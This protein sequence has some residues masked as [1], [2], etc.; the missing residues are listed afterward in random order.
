M[1][2]PEVGHATLYLDTFVR[3]NDQWRSFGRVVDRA[4]ADPEVAHAMEVAA[5]T[6][7]EMTQAWY[8]VDDVART[9]D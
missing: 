5:C 8:R 3:R 7:F 2:L 4:A 1:Q 9:V 6:A